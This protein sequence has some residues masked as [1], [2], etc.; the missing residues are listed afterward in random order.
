MLLF[1]FVYTPLQMTKKRCIIMIIN[2]NNKEWD[3]ILDS[4]SRNFNIFCTNN[5][6]TR[7]KRSSENNLY[8]FYSLDIISVSLAQ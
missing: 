2:N 7:I 8:I 6:I 1:K 5:K 3:I 4:L